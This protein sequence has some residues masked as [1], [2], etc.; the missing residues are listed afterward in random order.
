MSVPRLITVTVWYERRSAHA[1]SLEWIAPELGDAHLTLVEDQAESERP[2]RTWT[3]LVDGPTFERFARSW[4]LEDSTGSGPDSSNH[5]Q[6]ASQVP[7]SYEFD[8]LNWE[9][10]G[11]SPIIC[12]TVQVSDLQGAVA[13]PAGFS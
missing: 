5:N 4:R 3:G 10:D 8:G 6:N 7:R 13:G 11:E 9:A 12:V 2:F 1:R